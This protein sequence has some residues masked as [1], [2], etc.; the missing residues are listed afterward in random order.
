M[1]SFNSLPT[2][3]ILNIASCLRPSI[4]S[5]NALSQTDKRLY[6]TLERF[7]Y[8]EDVQHHQ[9]SSVYWAAEHGNLTTLRKAIKLG[10]AKIPTRGDYAS[11]LDDGSPRKVITTWGNRGQLYGSIAPSHHWD[12]DRDHPICIATQNGRE[13]VAKCSPDI[14]D[15]DDFCLLSLAIANG[16]NRAMI[17]TFIDLGV[18]QYTHGANSFFPL[19]IAAF[20]ADQETVGLLLS[21][22]KRGYL[23]YHIQRAFQVALSAG[24]AQVALQLFDYGGVNLNCYMDRWTTD[25]KHYSQPPLACAV[26]QDNFELAEKFC[27][28]GADADMASASGG[29][30]ALFHAVERKNLEMVDLLAKRTTDSIA[31]TRALS[32][33]VQCASSIDDPA[34]PE[35]QI[36]E[37][38][39]NHAVDCNFDDEDIRQPSNQPQFLGPLDSMACIMSN[40]STENGKFIPPIVHAV[41]K[42]NLRLVKLLLSFGADV[43]TGYRGLLETSS[44]LCCGRILSLAKDLGHQDIANFLVESGADPAMGPPLPD[45]RLK[46]NSR[47]CPMWLERLERQWREANPSAEVP[48]V[49]AARP[50]GQT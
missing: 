8:I 3:I 24:H 31:C 32:L 13:E 22:T 9:S 38:L 15:R 45:D 20:K 14:R 27:D 5:L 4:S 23:P 35:H 48:A 39:L 34:S 49:Y 37:I 17:R 25:R 1:V 7:L 50:N 18:H 16:S 36:V 12:I 11:R 26:L 28:N 47:K 2:E 6:S 33:A 10:K 43:N 19:H 21:S 30:V 44:K 41:H 40:H 42:G 46:C 29:R